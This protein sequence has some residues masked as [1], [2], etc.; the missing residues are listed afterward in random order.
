VIEI[1]LPMVIPLKSGSFRPLT[2]NDRLHF[3]ARARLVKDIRHAAALWARSKK[4]PP[5]DSITVQ[6]HYAPG[7]V[8][9]VTDAPNLTAT[10]KPA[11]DGLVDAG[12]VPDDKDDHVTEVMPVIHRGPGPRRL[13]L[14]IELTERRAA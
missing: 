7:S 9:S 8:R 6:L 12:I 10:S 13:W 3:R 4:I 11:I 14:T 2:H 1:D 5:A